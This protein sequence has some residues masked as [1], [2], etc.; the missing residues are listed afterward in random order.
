MVCS[1]QMSSVEGK[2]SVTS[3]KLLPSCFR[4]TTLLPLWCLVRMIRRA[5]PGVMLTGSLLTR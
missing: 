4:K 5:V 2:R 1:A 3:S